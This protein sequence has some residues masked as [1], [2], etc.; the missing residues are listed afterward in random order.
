MR[1]ITKTFKMKAHLEQNPKYPFYQKNKNLALELNEQLTVST[2]R[3]FIVWLKVNKDWEWV[4][5]TPPL[6]ENRASLGVVVLNRYTMRVQ[7][8]EAGFYDALTRI[9]SSLSKSRWIEPNFF[10]P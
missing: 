3:V 7:E 5:K 6:L 1:Y 4:G 10:E 8:T 2:T 9:Q